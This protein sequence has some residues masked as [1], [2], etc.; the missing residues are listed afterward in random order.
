MAVRSGDWIHHLYAES[1]PFAQHAKHID[2]ARTLAPEA[3]IVS[4]EELTQPEPPAKHELDEIF[5]R[6]RRQIGGKRE[7]RNVVKP[8]FSEHLQLLVLRR[9]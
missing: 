5:R 6:V 3:V 7:H 2:V 8:R 4:D 9:Q 1:I